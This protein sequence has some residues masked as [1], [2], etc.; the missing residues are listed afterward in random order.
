MTSGSPPLGN[1]DFSRLVVGLTAVLLLQSGSATPAAWGLPQLMTTLTANTQ[2]RVGFVEQRYLHFLT[3]PL[4]SSGWLSFTPPHR[5]EIATLAPK[6]ETVIADGSTLLIYR[7]GS[8]TRVD[9]H[10]H[11]EIG[12]MV[13]GIRGTLSGNLSML[14]QNYAVALR[15]NARHWRLSLVPLQKDAAHV[16]SEIL[17]SGVD[18]DVSAIDFRFPNGDRAEMTITRMQ[19]PR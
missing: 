17:I 9:L 3:Q 2:H 10:D 5:V 6:K 18:G 8:A 11:P 12:T 16:V 1:L 15:G 14:Q 4:E 13:D 19:I 7:A